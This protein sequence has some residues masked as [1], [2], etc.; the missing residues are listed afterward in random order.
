MAR[1]ERRAHERRLFDKRVKAQLAIGCNPEDVC[2]GKP[3]L[4]KATA[5]PFKV[6][7][8]VDTVA[9]KARKAAIDFCE[10]LAEAA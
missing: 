10:Q 2:S 4:L 5:S 7:H 3:Y 9:L 8:R 6:N 1:A